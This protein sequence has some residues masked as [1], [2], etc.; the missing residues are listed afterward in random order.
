[1]LKA[2]DKCGEVMA[3]LIAAQS[4]FRPVPKTMQAHHYKYADLAVVCANIYPILHEHGLGIVQTFAGGPDEGA[5]E[6]T[7][8]LIHT[9]G[10]TLQGSIKIPLPDKNDAQKTGT[11]CTYGRRYGMSALLGIVTEEDTDAGELKDAPR[12]KRAPAY[13]PGRSP[14]DLLHIRALG[15]NIKAAADARH[16]APGEFLGEIT[17]GRFTTF[18]DVTYQDEL[19]DIEAQFIQAASA[20]MAKKKETTRA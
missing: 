17:G 20:A 9:S 15:N 18:A 6:V 13:E 11:A 12:T 1:M 5:L 14:A 2:T 10:Q 7:T 3:A 8:T 4:K 16:Q 19:D